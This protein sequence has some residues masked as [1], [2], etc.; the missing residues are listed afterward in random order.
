MSKPGAKVKPSYHVTSVPPLNRFVLWDCAAMEKH[1]ETETYDKFVFVCVCVF[2]YLCVF[3]WVF[4]C[5][6]LSV[7]VY[8]LMLACTCVH[9]H[10]LSVFLVF[11]ILVT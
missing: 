9:V 4:A 5:V 11:S 1:Q 8:M 2:V 10:F 3:M 6:Y 7:C